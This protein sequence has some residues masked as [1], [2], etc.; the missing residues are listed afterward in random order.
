MSVGNTVI[1]K[2]KDHPYIV[3]GGVAGVLL[4]LA[5][6]RGGGSASTNS[7]GSGIYSVAADPNVLAL[8]AQQ[9]NA[10]R[11][12]AVASIAAQSQGEAIKAQRDV[13]MLAVSDAANIATAKIGASM[14]DTAAAG[15][16]TNYMLQQNFL[17]SQT[18]MASPSPGGPFVWGNGNMTLNPDQSRALGLDPRSHINIPVFSGV[19]TPGTPGDVGVINTANTQLEQLFN[20][21]LR[22]G[23]GAAPLETQILTTPPTPGTGPTQTGTALVDPVFLD[24]TSNGLR[25]ITDVTPGV[26]NNF[27]F[28][29][30]FTSIPGNGQLTFH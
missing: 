27:G 11:D 24:W 14:F 4:L 8:Q 6:R 13:Q 10:S 3:L 29:G 25:S 21:V 26:A 23:Q 28:S 12:V 22:A 15:L 19:G 30:S 20:N 2:V 17:N 9:I 1:E 16:T 7:G 5:L 18:G